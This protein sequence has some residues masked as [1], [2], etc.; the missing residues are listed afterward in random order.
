MKNVPAARK[1]LR[2]PSPEGIEKVVARLIEKGDPLYR[3]ICIYLGHRH[4]GLGLEEIGSYFGMKGPAVS[5]S[6]KRFEGRIKGDRDL[7]MMLAKM[8]KEVDLL[9]VETPPLLILDIG[10]LSGKPPPQDL[11]QVS[12]TCLFCPSLKP[13]Y[14]SC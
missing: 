4:S 11:P 5:Q 2:G 7:K 13:R 8:R 1:L 10:H 12:N 3:K 9:K 14:L 6:S